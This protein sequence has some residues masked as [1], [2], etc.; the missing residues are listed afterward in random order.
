MIS[1]VDKT[2]KKVLEL[3]LGSPLAFDVSFAIPDKDFTPVSNSQHTLNCYLHDISEHRELRS[4][5]PQLTLNTDGTYERKLP[6][7]RVKLSYCITAW[8][9]AAHTPAI[10]PAM[11][12]HKLLSQVLGIL[13]KYP[14]LPQAALQG[15]LTNQE[16][17]PPTSVILPNGIKNPGDFWNAIGGQ[18]RPALDY[19][20]TI[21]LAYFSDEQGPTVTA[22][23]TTFAHMGSNETE[24]GF[25]RI[26]G[27][28]VDNTIPPKGV[29]GAEVILNEK[30]QKVITGTQGHFSFGKISAG[31]YNVSVKATGFQDKTEQFQVPEADGNYNIALVP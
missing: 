25:T 7:A 1:D 12:E 9:P 27:Y 17:P 11:D 18:L 22:A 14:T 16:L 26:S 15:S 19:H 28:I 29:A 8:S 6:E 30:N 24:T 10:D 2:I 23:A 5:E 21:A 3:E 31:T 4:N 20:V 13:L